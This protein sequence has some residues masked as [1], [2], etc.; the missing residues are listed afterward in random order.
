M[1]LDEFRWYLDQY[2][3]F[4]NDNTIDLIFHELNLS[5]NTN[6]ENIKELI[7]NNNKDEDKILRKILSPKKNNIIKM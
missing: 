7:R 5:I 1:D 4:V 2:T 3:D 6:E